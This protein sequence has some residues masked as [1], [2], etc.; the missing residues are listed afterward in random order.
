M[1]AS[2]PVQYTSVWRFIGGWNG[3]VAVYSLRSMVLEDIDPRVRQGPDGLRWFS[4]S[5]SLLSLSLSLSLSRSFSLLSF[6]SSFFSL[7]FILRPRCASTPLPPPRTQS[8]SFWPSDPFG[9]NVPLRILKLSHATLHCTM[10]ELTCTDDTVGTHY[11]I[12]WIK[13]N[14][15]KSHLF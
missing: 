2:A 9:R 10:Y 15:F 1:P 6:P 4:L 7:L 3:V 8:P 11:S 13:A 14:L 5:L 12:R